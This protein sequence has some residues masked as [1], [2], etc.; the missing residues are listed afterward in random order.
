M[1]PKARSIISWE[2]ETLSEVSLEIKIL[3]SSAISRKMR[4]DGFNATGVAGLDCKVKR[5]DL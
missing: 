3:P 5:R 1:R 4:V 2:E